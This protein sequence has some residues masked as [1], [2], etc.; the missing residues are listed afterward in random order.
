MALHFCVLLL[1]LIHFCKTLSLDITECR[2]L[3][4]MSLT[5][6]IKLQIYPN[7]LSPRVHLLGLQQ[8]SHSPSISSDLLSRL[9]TCK[10][11]LDLHSHSRISCHYN[12][13]LFSKQILFI[14]QQN[15]VVYT[16]LGRSAVEVCLRSPAPGSA[17][18]T[19]QSGHAHHYTCHIFF[20]RT[21]HTYN[22]FDHTSTTF[23]TPHIYHLRMIWLTI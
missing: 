11:P 3:Q 20:L 2:E 5:A 4:T 10:S 23:I 12:F 18:Y 17:A 16:S 1:L 21:S 6:A 14:L 22:T 7:L 8:Q 19:Q 13:F 9:N 15:S